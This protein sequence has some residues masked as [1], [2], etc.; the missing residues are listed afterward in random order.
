MNLRFRI[1]QNLPRD[2]VALRALLSIASIEE[3]EAI[4]TACVT[5]GQHPRLLVNPGFVGQHANTPTKLQTLIG[6]ELLHVALGHTRRYT[7]CSPLDNL[8]FDCL[9]NATLAKSDPTPERTALFRDFYCEEKFPECFLRPP[10]IWHPSSHVQLPKALRSRRAEG[11]LFVKDVYRRLWSDRGASGSE[12][13]AALLRGAACLNQPIEVA[14]GQISLLGAHE[15]EGVGDMTQ[16]M[17][18]L[19]EHFAD[20]ISKE[21]ADKHEKRGVR[22]NESFPFRQSLK[23]AVGTNPRIK[24]RLRGL[25]E[26]LAH[27]TGGAR[28]RS[29]DARGLTYVTPIPC[30]DRRAIVRHLLGK[31]PMLYTATTSG[32]AIRASQRIHVYLDVSGSMNSV[33]PALYG[34]M[35]DCRDLIHHQLHLFSD[36]VA[37]ITFAQL[38]AGLRITTMGTD[39]NC[40]ATH[41]Q[42]QSVR[43]ALIVTDGLVGDMSQDTERILKQTDFAIGL[44]GPYTAT[45]ELAR[46]GIRCERLD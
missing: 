35:H 34:A 10:S 31:Q 12:I 7:T 3:T 28:L 46:L 14:I 25:F 32:P 21:I 44:T 36:E 30:K 45:P 20:L 41:M 11:L 9:I 38:K 4:P 27:G 18:T 24:K 2:S 37:D 6:H 39:I 15:A 13:R 5:L 33:I 23:E 40:V 16:P 1:A 43:R 22:L 8:V 42:Q 17:S 26:C 19:T 29:Q